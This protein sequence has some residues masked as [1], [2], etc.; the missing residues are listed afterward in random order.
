MESPTCMKCGHT[1]F[2]VKE[3]DSGIAP[4]KLRFLRCVFCNA[5][6]GLEDFYYFGERLR[7]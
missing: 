7:F 5:I 1:K 6:A 4:F 3:E 2:L